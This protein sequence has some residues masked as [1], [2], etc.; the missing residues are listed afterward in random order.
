VILRR[1]VREGA[2]CAGG[3]DVD[4]EDSS[5]RSDCHDDSER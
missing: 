5:S 1:D 4:G 3:G 2:V